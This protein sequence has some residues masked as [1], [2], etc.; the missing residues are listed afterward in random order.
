MNATQ[1]PFDPH[2]SGACLDHQHLLAENFPA[3][4]GG[5]SDI[6]IDKWPHSFSTIDVADSQG[7]PPPWAVY[8]DDIGRWLK[9]AWLIVW[10]EPMVRMAEGAVAELTQWLP[11]T[12]DLL[13]RKSVFWLYTTPRS[14][15]ESPDLLFLGRLF[16]LGQ[17]DLRIVEIAYLLSKSN[18]SALA[19]EPLPLGSVVDDE[20]V[21]TILKEMR[22]AQ[23]PYFAIDRRTVSRHSIRRAE[24]VG[25]NTEV[26]FITLR[27]S[28]GPRKESSNGDA[29]I[30][31]AF[32]WPVSGHWRRQWYPNESVR[33]PVWI[34]PYIKGPPNKPFKG[35]PGKMV[36]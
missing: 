13:P 4:H 1:L 21:Q 28:L 16:Q 15:E 24:R 32:Q 8:M 20:G 34:A 26:G 11:V 10:T 22:F 31:W 5:W 14:S 29:E 19:S 12:A 36:R 35:N 7:R 3:G 18:L 33:K 17:R 6:P 2:N 30:D 27:R 9:D 23:S 25:G